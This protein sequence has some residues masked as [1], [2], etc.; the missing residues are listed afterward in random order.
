MALPTDENTWNRFEIQMDNK[1]NVYYG[2]HKIINCR[3]LIN[4]YKIDKIYCEKCPCTG[5]V[6]KDNCTCDCIITDPEA[7]AHHR[8]YMYITD[9]LPFGDTYM[10]VHG[11][12]ES[13][14]LNNALKIGDLHIAHAHVHIKFPYNAIKFPF[15]PHKVYIKKDI[16]YL[17]EPIFNRQIYTLILC[18]RNLGYFP[19]EFLKN[20]KH[21][22]YA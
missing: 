13:P 14:V 11:G 18:F 1:F 5:M 19:T 15:I 2:E 10:H 20:I 12:W 17:M 4:F 9:G 7:Q 22:L 6:H 21:H 8:F 3:D 16:S